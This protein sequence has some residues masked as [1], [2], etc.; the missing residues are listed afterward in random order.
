MVFSYSPD[1]SVASY[2]TTFNNDGISFI[3]INTSNTSKIIDINTNYYESDYFWHELYANN[4]IDKKIYL[5]GQ[6]SDNSS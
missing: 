6:T 5:N 4:E 1:S 3:L 2:S